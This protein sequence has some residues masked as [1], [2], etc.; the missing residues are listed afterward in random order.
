[1]LADDELAIEGTPWYATYLDPEKIIGRVQQWSPRTKFVVLLRN[2][3]EAFWSLLCF[4][5]ASP[6][7]PAD[8]PRAPHKA[9]LSWVKAEA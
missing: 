6:H 9:T 7:M 5:Y 2:P 8:Y 3:V 4:N 1:M